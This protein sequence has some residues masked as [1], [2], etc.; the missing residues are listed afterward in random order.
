MLDITAN[1][2]NHLGSRASGNNESIRFE[3]M[4]RRFYLSIERHFPSIAFGIFP[5]QKLHV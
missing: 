1:C 2:P 5:K 3:A 4:T